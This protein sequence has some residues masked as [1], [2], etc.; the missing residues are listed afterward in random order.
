M[1]TKTSPHFYKTAASN[2]WSTIVIGGGQAGLAAGYHL[3]KMQDDF[4]ILDAS[5]KTGDSWR[6]RWDSLKLFTPKEFTGLPGWEYPSNTSVLT[7]DQMAEYLELYAKKFS[8]PVRAGNRVIRLSKNENGFIVETTR[9]VFT[10]NR[11]IVATGT[12]QLPYT[13]SFSTELDPGIVQLHAAS[14]RNPGEIPYGNVLV[15]G[16]ATSGIEIAIE[17]SKTHHAMLAGKPSFVVPAGAF[18]FGPKFYW[19]FVNNVL[20]IKTPVG[21]KAKQRIVNGGGVIPQM[22]SRLQAAM[23][24]KLP[25]VTGVKNGLPLL[26]DG[27]VLPVAAV[28]WCTGYRPDFGWLDIPGITIENGWPLTKRG[29][30]TVVQ[31]LYFV[32]IPFQFGLSSGLV[33]GVGR[34]AAY[35]VHHMFHRQARLEKI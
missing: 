6:A 12:N 35:I 7:K 2:H 15:V 5:V 33:G 32:G 13:P 1:Q 28:I 31:G 34:D 20:T 26:E 17:L 8:L 30:S 24:E 16:S 11:V 18:R 23:V 4:I 14:Y 19:W 29:V 27:Q 3:Q 9:A 25:R 10:C 22:L 21:R